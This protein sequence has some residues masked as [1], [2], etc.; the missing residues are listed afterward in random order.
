MDYQPA[1]LLWS[2]TG[3]PAPSG[4]GK[5]FANASACLQSHLKSVDGRKASFLFG[6]SCQS[7]LDV[8]E[9]L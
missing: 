5:F 1:D 8:D 4:F 2:G 3:R 9:A 7:R 6:L